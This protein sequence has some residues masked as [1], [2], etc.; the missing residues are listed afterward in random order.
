MRLPA[1]HPI[2]D[3]SAP[4]RREHGVGR[5]VA[6]DRCRTSAG[7]GSTRR[8]ARV[9]SSYS[10]AA[11][12]HRSLSSLALDQRAAAAVAERR[13]PAGWV[14]VVPHAVRHQRR[15]GQPPQQLLAR[16]LDV[17]HDESAA[18]SLASCPRGL[19]LAT[20][21]REAVEDVAV[22][23]RP[24]GQ[25]LPTMRDQQVVG[26][27]ARPSPS[28]ARPRG[29]ARSRPRWRRAAC[30][31]SRSCGT[32]RCAAR[33]AP[34]CPCPPREGPGRSRASRHRPGRPAA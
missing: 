21:A 11:A 27:P 22:A 32:P 31:P 10:A 19:G 20:R 30:R 13:R 8:A 28:A 29:R 26:A 16:H 33:R 14:R 15:A 9:R 34:A 4:A 7:P 3:A 2:A 17:E 24:V 6:V 23:R 25:P 12:H 1:P 5:A 18:P